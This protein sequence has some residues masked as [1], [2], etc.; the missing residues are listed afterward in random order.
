MGGLSSRDAGDDDDDDAL[1]PAGRHAGR[2]RAPAP[3]AAAA[4]P[5]PQSRKRG[6]GGAR[7]RVNIVSEAV[8]PKADLSALKAAFA[9]MAARGAA[10]GQGARPGPA[11][12]TF[13][14]ETVVLKAAFLS[15]FALPPHISAFG[16]LLYRIF[17]RLP[18]LLTATRPDDLSATDGLNFPE[19]LGS[20]AVFDGLAAN[21]RS[22]IDSDRLI[23]EA[24]AGPE[25]EHVA[26][27]NLQNKNHYLPELFGPVAPGIPVLAS[28]L[29][30][31]L[32]GLAW[33]A[34]CQ[35]QATAAGAGSPSATLDVNK[36][37]CD[38]AENDRMADV[39]ASLI[40]FS[41]SCMSPKGPVSANIEIPG[42][43]ICSRD[44]SLW[45]KRQTPHL[46]DIFRAYVHGTLSVLAGASHSGSNSPLTATISTGASRAAAPPSHADGGGRELS[47]DVSKVLATS[48]I[49]T[50]LVDM[51]VLTWFLPASATKRVQW[52]LLYRATDHGRSLSSLEAQVFKYPG[53]TLLVIHIESTASKEGYQPYILGAFIPVPWQKSKH[54]WGNEDTFLFEMSPPQHN[55][56]KGSFEVLPTV[57]RNNQY[58]S[59]HPT[60][61][62]CFGGNAK[63]DKA[64]LVIEPSLESGWWRNDYYQGGPFCLSFL[65][66]W[67]DSCAT[68]ENFL[69][70]PANCI[71]QHSNIA[72]YSFDVFV[73]EN[74]ST[75]LLERIGKTSC[76]LCPVSRPLRLRLRLTTFPSHR[77]H[78]GCH[79]D[80]R[81]FTERAIF[82]QIRHLPGA[83]C[84][85]FRRLLADP[86]SSIARRRVAVP[87]RTPRCGTVEVWGLG[88]RAALQRQQGERA[89]D[90]RDA[91]RRAHVNLG[92]SDMTKALLNMAGLMQ[93]DNLGVQRATPRDT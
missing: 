3:A 53:P 42:Q 59:Y 25:N 31:F 85:A 79:A 69:P 23:F 84:C 34:R 30:G 73:G 8:F 18:C 28:D 63:P 32:C 51:W 71:H 20:V 35:F 64:R 11:G 38:R 60:T 45:F 61:G 48:D 78:T 21:V 9:S 58:I 90:A 10:G 36:D 68:Y 19:F 16:D 39:V 76:S 88:G 86:S 55:G 12:G 5:P 14:R 93:A 83:S 82:D 87:P 29:H 2:P 56:W 13:D 89:F 52:D 33:C 77:S 47:V 6:G 81:L 75:F 15:S 57:K 43:W 70:H 44:F 1:P 91:E 37:A 72:F 54:T 22:D 46:Y 4:E 7:A 27:P 41:N 50:T 80:V 74:V 65:S 49:I 92:N 17:T 26:P 67:F 40:R 66:E 24:L 62:L